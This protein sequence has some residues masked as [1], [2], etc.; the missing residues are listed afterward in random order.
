MPLMWQ[1]NLTRHRGKIDRGLIKKGVSRNLLTFCTQLLHK[2]HSTRIC[3]RSSLLWN[4]MYDNLLKIQL[5][6]DVRIITFAENTR[7]NC[8]SNRMPNR[9]LRRKYESDVGIGFPM[10]ERKQPNKTKAIMLMSNSGYVRVSDQIPRCEIE[11]FAKFKRLP[12]K[13]TGES[14]IYLKWIA[15]I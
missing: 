8:A 3:T 5:L 7:C 15:S 9:N 14:H 11:Y 2:R 4:V 1:T 6:D 10:D 13:S 12:I